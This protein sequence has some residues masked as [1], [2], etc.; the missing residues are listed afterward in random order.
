MKDIK[1]LFHH[2]GWMSDKKVKEL[3]EEV[4]QTKVIE[5]CRLGNDCEWVDYEEEPREVRFKFRVPR[6]FKIDK[7]KKLIVYG[8]IDSLSEDWGQMFCPDVKWEVKFVKDGEY[9][10]VGE[11]DYDQIEFRIYFDISYGS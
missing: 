8:A 2:Q 1:D 6:K 10:K 7:E 5:E 9:S 4:Y 3:I 11:L